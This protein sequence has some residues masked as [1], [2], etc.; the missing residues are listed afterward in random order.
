MTNSISHLHGMMLIIGS[1]VF[2]VILLTISGCE[3]VEKL[4]PTVDS[5]VLNSHE[6]TGSSSLQ[7]LQRG[8]ILYITKCANCHSPERV[9]RYSYDHWERIIPDMAE[10]T[11]LNQQETN[12]LRSYINAV[13]AQT[14]D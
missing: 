4:A 12:D 8:R 9:T 1:I 7:T 14:A 2:A 6:M 11:K 10:R 5:L 13:L 3:T